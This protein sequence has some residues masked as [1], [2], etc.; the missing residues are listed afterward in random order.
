MLKNL[1][2]RMAPLVAG[3]MVLTSINSGVADFC[4]ISNI[5]WPV[6]SPGNQYCTVYVAQ[7]PN[8]PNGYVA[9]A[10]TEENYFWWFDDERSIYAEGSDHSTVATVYPLT[11]TKVAVYVYSVDDDLS[12]ASVDRNYG[13]TI[14]NGP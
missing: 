14:Y 12:W 13:A 2:K 3:V 7:S 11:V 8:I 4:Y 5:D 10:A 1:F 6:D 9:P